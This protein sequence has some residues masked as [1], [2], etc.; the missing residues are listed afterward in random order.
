ML[1]D[2]G[3]HLVQTMCDKKIGSNVSIVDN[4]YKKKTY[5]QY[6]GFLNNETCLHVKDHHIQWHL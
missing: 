3:V 2:R 5:I 4:F 6:K 1:N